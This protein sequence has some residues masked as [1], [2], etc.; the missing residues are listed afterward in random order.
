[1]AD[2]Q[3]HSSR[4]RLFQILEQRVRPTPL[5]II[6]RIDQHDPRRPHGGSVSEHGLQRTDLRD[7]DRPRQILIGLLHILGQTREHAKIGM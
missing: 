5:Q 2:Q 3:E 6:D 7:G 4:R 1:M